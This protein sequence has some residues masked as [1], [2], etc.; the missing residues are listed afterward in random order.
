MAVMPSEPRTTYEGV[1][2][3]TPR[4]EPDELRPNVPPRMM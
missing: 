2:V 4:I 3:P 1:T